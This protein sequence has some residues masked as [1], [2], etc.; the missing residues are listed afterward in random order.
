MAVE[1]SAPGADLQRGLHRCVEPASDRDV[2]GQRDRLHLNSFESRVNKDT[3][4][5]IFR[6]ERKG[7]RILRPLRRQFRDVL[8]DRLQRRHHPR[9]F[10]RLAPAGEGDAARTAAARGADWQRRPRARQRTSRRSATPGCRSFRGR[11]ESTV[12]SACTKST[13]APLGAS[14]RALASMG[15]E[16]STP[17]TKP[18]GAI[19]SASAMLVEPQPQPTSMI[20]LAPAGSRP[21]DQDLRDR[22]QQDVLLG[23][24][25]GPALT[26]RPV[27][28]GDLVGIPVVSCGCFHG[29]D[30]TA[31]ARL[32]K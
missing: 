13:G 26:V 24:A 17:S 25:V 30:L 27:P 29:C 21:V 9:I 1:R 8:I 19:F 20:A 10:A 22:R 32:G 18:D 5:A 31:P 12:A 7:P 3:A 23:L 28:I 11:T 14:S 4:H 15:P 16:M 6:G 2:E